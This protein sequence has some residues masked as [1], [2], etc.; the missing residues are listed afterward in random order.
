MISVDWKKIKYLK[1]NKYYLKDIESASETDLKNIKV[2]LLMLMFKT[3]FKFGIELTEKIQVKVM[4][5]MTYSTGCQHTGSNDFLS[6]WW[7]QL[8]S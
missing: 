4:F 1:E 2:C 5:F 6:S 7:K 3:F 8:F